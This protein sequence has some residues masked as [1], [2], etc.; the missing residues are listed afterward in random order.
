MIYLNNAIE[1]HMS[2]KDDESI[3]KISRML[4]IGGTMLAQHCAECGAPL[5]RYKGNII[6]PLC[7]TGQ[8]PPVQAQKKPV[9]T[10]DLSSTVSPVTESKPSPIDLAAEGNKST[11]INSE[12]PVQSKGLSTSSLPDLE[13]ILVK[14]TIVL[15]QSMH[16]EQDPRKIKEFLELI[17]KS[18]DIID[19]LKK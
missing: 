13:A 15:A 11:S 10:T 19:R 14:K 12:A 8:K 2:Q 17:E 1:E 18:L 3:S 5:F 4:E 6:C 7:D 16:Q 9:E